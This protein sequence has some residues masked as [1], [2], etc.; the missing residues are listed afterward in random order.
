MQAGGGAGEALYRR[1]DPALRGSGHP[2]RS[3]GA[4]GERP[5]GGGR[6]YPR[7]GLTGAD[8]R[9]ATRESREAGAA[10]AGA[11]VVV[12]VMGWLASFSTL[13]PR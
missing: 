8:P 3:V 2:F 7:R 11:V 4:F 9:M 6:I 13:L 5:L 12:L 10:A 1:H